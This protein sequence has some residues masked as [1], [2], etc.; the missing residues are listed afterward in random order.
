M[1]RPA[2]LIPLRRW[3][4]RFTSEIASRLTMIERSLSALAAD[5]STVPAGPTLARDQPTT[6][7]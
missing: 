2:R 3:S 7:N 6:E 5:R 4:D 1:R